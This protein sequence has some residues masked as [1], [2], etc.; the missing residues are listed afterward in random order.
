MNLRDR[1]LDSRGQGIPKGYKSRL[2]AEKV[3]IAHGLA[4]RRD[5]EGN[6]Q[7]VGRDDELPDNEA[8]V[9]KPDPPGS[10]SI[11]AASTTRTRSGAKART[12]CTRFSGADPPSTTSQPG[13]GER[14]SNE[15][16]SG[17]AASSP[18][19]RLPTVRMTC[20]PIR[21]ASLQ[22]IIGGG[23]EPNGSMRLACFRRK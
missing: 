17:P 16:R 5:Q 21:L 12:R 19:M 11:S 23:P 22:R 18:I 4:Q 15:A 20:S 8:V 6:R 9:D 2:D 7:I 13:A 10:S 1:P 14:C 3:H